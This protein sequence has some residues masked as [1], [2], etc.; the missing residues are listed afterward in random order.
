MF[1]VLVCRVG[2]VESTVELRHLRY[3]VAV[4]EAENVLRAATQ[5]LHV[6]QPAVSR[7]IRDLE[8][9]LRVQ[10]FERTGKS[11]R[12]TDAGSLFLKQARG[13]LERTD[14]A[15]R[16]LR[17]F[18]EIGETELHVGYTPALRTQIV[19]PALREFQKEMPK[20]RVKLHDWSAERIFTGLRDGQLQLGLIGR[21]SKRAQLR[22]LR[23]EELIRERV[24]LAVSVNHPFARR[25]SVSLTDAAKEPFVGLTREDFPDYN[26]YLA[27][28]FAPVKDKPDVIEEHDSM[29][30]VISAIE[31][32]TGV[33]LAVDALSYIVGSKVKL[34]RLT[35]EPKPF[36]FGI[37]ARRGRLLPAAE[38]FRQCAIKT[39]RLGS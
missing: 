14:E 28:I 17:S 11:V 1:L 25:R 18:A 21:P 29:S 3:F 36:S 22:D 30:S 20:V 27:A 2:I 38:R 4:A 34:I 39:A 9:E 12:L 19:S 16:N 35:P 13:I 37:V 15:V 31:A 5:K 24:R 33:G 6:S 10:L 26:A 7:Q 8:N 32:G 23:F